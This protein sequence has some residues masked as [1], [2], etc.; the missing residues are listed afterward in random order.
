MPLHAPFPLMLEKPAAP[1]ACTMYQHFSSPPFPAFRT[2]RLLCVFILLQLLLPAVLAEAGPRRQDIYAGYRTLSSSLPAQRLMIHMGVWYPTRR[3]PGNMKTGEWTFRAARNAPVMQGPWPVVILSHDVTGS[4][5]THHDL[6]A[7]LAAKGFIVAAP[8]HDHDNGEDMELLLSDRELPVRALQLRAAL[9]LLLEHPQLGI[10]ADKA[11][12]GF[13]GFGLP[14][15]AGLLLAGAELTPNAWSSFCG[16]ENND[17]LRT[18]TDLSLPAAESAAHDAEPYLRP[19]GAIPPISAPQAVPQRPLAM[20]TPVP[21][22]PAKKQVLLINIARA[23]ENPSP[24]IFGTTL[25]DSPWCSPFLA[26]RMDELV[27][28]MQHRTQEREEKNAMMHTAVEAR[29]QLFRRLTDSVARSHQRQLRLA[30]SDAL[31]VPPVALPLLPPLSHDSPVADA[32]FRALVFVSP[33]YSMLFDPESLSA[34]QVPALFIGA[35]LDIWNRPSEQ[36]ERFVDMMGNRPEYL[37]LHHADAAAL[38][39]PCPESDP[40]KPLSA[41]CNSVDPERREAAH[42]RLVSVLQEF[43]D[44]TLGRDENTIP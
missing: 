2:L 30:K 38:Q 42:A 29:G 25:K 10:Q 17:R 15:P 28:E 32:R 18:E 1:G 6:A 11:R 9:D 36:A 23:E 39:A 40:A 12:I 22:S 34:V 21:E 35:D 4:A 44:R 3:K 41:L 5:W 33:G 8:T 27:S 43:F 13:L 26:G 20:Q 37:L 16:T 7:A 31:P 19:D 24:T 14:S